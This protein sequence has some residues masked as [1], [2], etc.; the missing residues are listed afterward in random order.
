MDNITDSTENVGKSKNS[1][2]TEK[3]I[4]NL[5]PFQPGQSGNPHG[6]PK[7]AL[8][9]VTL[10]KKLAGAQARGTNEN[11]EDVKDI[12]AKMYG[13]DAAEAVTNAHIYIAN[14]HKAASKGEEWAIKLLLNYIDGMPRQSIDLGGQK[15]NPLKQD[16]YIVQNSEQKELLEKHSNTSDDL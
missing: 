15:D 8:S 7:G 3:R 9:L 6:R 16:V 14:V 13:E 10:M 5:T 12:L 4:A 11:G 2:L 1:D